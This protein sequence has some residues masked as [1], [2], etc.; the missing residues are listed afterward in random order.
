MEYVITN[1]GVAIANL[2]SA[3]EVRAQG[4]AEAVEKMKAFMNE[5]VSN[6]GLTSSTDFLMVECG[7]AFLAA[8]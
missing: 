7:P 8:V 1:R 4:A 2:I 5:S 3:Q 6:W